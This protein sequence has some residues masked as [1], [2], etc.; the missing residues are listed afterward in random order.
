MKIEAT[1]V[2]EYLSK[3]PE[4]RQ[5]YFNQLRETI[6]SALPEGFEEGLQYGMIGYYIPHTIYPSGYHVTPE[7]PLPFMNIAS[8]KNH[9]ALYHSGIYAHKPLLEWFQDEYHKH[10]K[11]KLDMGKSC[12][13]I[14]HPEHIPFELISLLVGK[15]SAEEYI[16]IYERALNKK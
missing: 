7:I 5:P 14:K 8:Q 9:I 16:E 4:D 11:Y 12:V 3:V 13:R 1:S 10:C 15:M 2:E 6:L